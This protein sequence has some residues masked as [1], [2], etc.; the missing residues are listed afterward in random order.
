MFTIS[1][2]IFLSLI[3][4][5]QYIKDTENPFSS[6]IVNLKWL[7]LLNAENTKSTAMEGIEYI[8]VITLLDIYTINKKIKIF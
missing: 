8:I 2:I 7:L 4:T 5:L 6:S 3:T 1:N